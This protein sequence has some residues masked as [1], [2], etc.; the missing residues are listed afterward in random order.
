MQQGVAQGLRLFLVFYEN[1]SDHA[2]WLPPKLIRR[3]LK[4]AGKV[5][6]DRD[7]FRVLSCVLLLSIV[8]LTACGAP[9]APTAV[10]FATYTAQQV[11]DAFAS[12]GLDIQ[13]VQRDMQVGRDTPTTFSDR[14]TFEIPIVAPNGGQIVIF[15]SSANMQAWRDYIE[16]LRNDRLTR[17][18]VIYVYENHNVMVQVNANLPLEEANR[19]R[20][21]VA[22]LP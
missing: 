10:P 5:V 8:L 4:V 14:Y 7:M 15:D 12:A 13:N 16:Q 21:V 18:D 11:L 19:F 1:L 20:D 9:A 17:R 3:I 2:S 22:G 6:E